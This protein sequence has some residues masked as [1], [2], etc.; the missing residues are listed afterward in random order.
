MSRSF[1]VPLL[2]LSAAYVTSALA[3]EKPWTEVRSQHFRVLT[4]GSSGDARKVLHEFEQL[5]WVFAN[6]FPGARLDSGAPLTVFAVRDQGTA[7]SLDPFMWKRMGELLAGAFHP[8]WERQ[9][10]MVRLDSWGGEGSKEVVYH[11]YTHSILRMN[12]HWL[13]LWLNE[14][15]AEFYGYS[16]FEEHRIYLG[17]PTARDR[18][19]RSRTPMPVQTLISMRAMPSDEQLFYAES[20]ALVHFL[21]YGPGMENGKRMDN[22]F[23]LLQQGTPQ[24]KAFEQVF[25]DFKSVNKGLASYMQQPTFTTTVLKDPVQIDDKSTA[26]RVMTVAETEAELGGFH[27]WTHDNNGARPLLEQ[28]LKDD[29]KLGL[30]HENMGFLDFA[31]GKDAEAVSQFAQAYTLDSKLYLSLFAKTMMSSLPASNRVS[32]L[33]EFGASIGKVLQVNPEFAPAYVQLSRLAF[34]EGDLA[35]ALLMSRKAEELEPSLAGYHL[36]SGQILRRMGKGTDAAA[37]AQ[38]VADRWIGPDHNEAVE[39]WNSVPAAERGEAIFA[40]APK[41]SEAVEGQVKAIVCS[42]KEQ[43]WSLVLDKGSRSLT[44]HKKGPFATGFSD[45]IW[46]GGDHFNHCHHI[47][48]LRAIVHYRPPADASYAGDIAELEIRDDLPEPLAKQ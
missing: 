2:L 36:L 1:L 13:P 17:A 14:G 34:H 40:V 9:Y 23:A 10:A 11:E 30:A 37:S 41:D 43:E 35:A 21:I 33:N 6:R 48:G 3:S 19:L 24:N 46:Y 8:G 5:R 4:N 29:P 20:W 42:E 15:T 47:E 32:D 7:K 31:D 22:F 16:R 28:A 44:F 27:L 38:F 18:E 45:T 25:G 26:L 39:L 12:S